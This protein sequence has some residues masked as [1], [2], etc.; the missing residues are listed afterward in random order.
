MSRPQLIVM[1]LTIATASALALAQ[2][3]QT[4]RKAAEAAELQQ[5]FRVKGGKHWDSSPII[6]SL[7]SSRNLSEL[8]TDTPV[9]FDL[10]ASGPDSW[11]WIRPTTALLV[12]D[13]AHEGNVTSGRQLFGSVSFGLPWT[14]GYAA[15]ATLD[16]DHDGQLVGAELD[17]LGA[18]FDRNSNG[19]SDPGE[20]VPVTSLG[21]VS[22]A[23]HPLTLDGDV[24]T[25]PYGIKLH[26]GHEL[27]TWDWLS[28]RMDEAKP[29]D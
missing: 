10:D 16:T 4:R 24:L 8:V 27:P 11:S 15:L 18:W 2:E 25:T 29:V 12:W 26:D 20:V 22:I 1:V 28:H 17:G 5:V 14:D 6:F 3:I 19:L 21:I 7:G 13:P 9:R 23:V